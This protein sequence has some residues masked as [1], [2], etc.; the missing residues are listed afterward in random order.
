VLSALRTGWASRSQ[1]GRIASYALPHGGRVLGALACAAGSAA[2]GLA[3]VLV[4]RDLIDTLEHGHGSSA[5]AAALVGLGFLALVGSGLLG[6]AETRLT[7]SI[8]K[9]VVARLRQQLFDHLLSQS[10]GYF[11]RRRTGELLSRVLNDVGGIDGIIGPTLL[12]LAGA[13]CTL[14]ASLVFMFVFSWQLSLV[15][16]VLFPLVVVSLRASGRPMVRRRRAVQERF[17]GLSAHLQ[18]VLG[19][20]GILLVKSFGREPDE[21]ARFAAANEELRQLEIASG[22]AG[23]WILMGVTLLGLLG[24]ISLVLVGSYLVSDHAISLGTLVAFIAVAAAGFIRGLGGLANSLA[25]VITSLPMWERVFEVLDAPPDVAEQPSA[26]TLRRPRGAVTFERVT[27]SYPSQTAPAIDDVSIDIPPGSLVAIVGPSGAGKTTLS[28]LVPRFYDPQA[29]RILIDGHNLRELTL[30]SITDAVGLVLQDT[31]LFHASMRDNL[32]YGRPDATDEELA[33]AV[34]HAALEPVVASMNQ[35]LDTLVGER[36]HRLSGGEKQ[37]VAIARVIL[38]DPAILVLDE[39]T[40]HLDSIS[41]ALIQEAMTELFRGRTSLVIAHRL[42]TI[43]SADMIVVLDGGRL[44][45]CGTHDQLRIA[46]GLY[47]QMEATQF[48]QAS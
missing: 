4:L 19:I 18:E 5:H 29:G 6:I 1:A 3:P 27:F 21:R 45:E 39:A 16:V 38:R 7:L 41:E 44:V 25:S 9:G 12:A 8:G 26:T 28:N 2:L 13:I 14:L 20:S 15:T 35:G 42:S 37:R 47:S 17:A 31:F 10:I 23:Q 33:A 48:R 36:G 11:T 34:K 40:S 22:M 32:V 43:R 46:G 24:P 30:A